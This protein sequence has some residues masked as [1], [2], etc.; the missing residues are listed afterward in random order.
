MKTSNISGFFA[1]GIYKHKTEHNIGTLWRSAYILG[2]SYI[3]SVGKRYKKQTSDVLKTWARIPMFYYPEFEDLL[4]N[5]PYDCRLVGIE[6]DENAIPLAEFKHPMRA[7]YLLG[8]EDN[9]LPPEIRDK[10]HYL[11]KIPGNSS[12]NVAVT[13]SIVINDRITK[14]PTILP[15]NHKEELE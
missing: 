8:S 10:C 6:L 14:I 7:I 2:A 11:V 13:G 5:I 1:V 4:E 3:F 12:L 15:P 9:G